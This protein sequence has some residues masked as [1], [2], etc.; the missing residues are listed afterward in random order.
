MIFHDLIAWKQAFAKAVAEVGLVESSEDF[1]AL[2]PTPY[3]MNP[4]PL[5]IKTKP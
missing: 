3:T 2:H 4:T 1:E 5:T